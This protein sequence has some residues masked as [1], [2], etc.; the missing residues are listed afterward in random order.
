[1]AL[2]CRQTS[3][4][5]VRTGQAQTIPPRQRTQRLLAEHK[6]CKATLRRTRP[7]PD[8]DRAQQNAFDALCRKRRC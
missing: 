6:D 3:A 8:V 7:T 4:A 2:G 1:M 5:A